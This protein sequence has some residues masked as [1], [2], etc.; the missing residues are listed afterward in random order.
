MV[1]CYKESNID[2]NTDRLYTSLCTVTQCTRSSSR[3]RT[4]YTNI[5]AVNASAILSLSFSKRNKENAHLAAAVSLSFHTFHR[6]SSRL[7]TSTHTRTHTRTPP[8]CS[9]TDQHTPTGSVLKANHHLCEH[10]RLSLQ[11]MSPPRCSRTFVFPP[12]SSF[13]LLSLNINY[14]LLCTSSCSLYTKRTR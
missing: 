6:E 8:L 13:F 4:L 1:A 12:S 11:Q 7:H 10:P 3:L 14:D 5:G 9:S 2:L